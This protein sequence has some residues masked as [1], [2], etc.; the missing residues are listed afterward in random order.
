MTETVTGTDRSNGVSWSELLETDSHPV[1]EVL[2]RV[3]PMP[4][5]NT[6]VPAAAYTSRAW[7][8]LE[9]ER[10]WSRV[11]QMACLEEDIPEVGDHLV[12]DIAHLSFVVVR[13]G[14]DEI[15]AFNNACL[16]RGRLLKEG[17]GR[18]ATNLRCPFHGWSWNLDGSLKEIPCEWDFPELDKGL[19]DL[20]QA[21]VG[22]WQ[23]FVFINPD[24]A[25]EPL[26]AFLEGLDE[27][28]ATLP[29]T[30]RVKRAHVRKIMP[31]NW[32]ACQEAF[33]EAYHVVATHPTLMDDLGDANS[34]YDVFGNFS[35]AVSPHAVP[36]PHLANMAHHEHPEDARHF[37]RWRHP[38]NGHVY[39]RGVAAADG[40]ALVEVTD[41]NGD[42]SVFDHRGTW[43]EGPLLQADPHMCI[44]IGGPLLEG[45]DQ[46][47]LMVTDS[48]GGV[49]EA[50]TGAA[51]ARR[52]QLRRRWGDKLDVDG[53]SDAEMIDAIFYSVF[54]NLSP[55]GPFNELF[56]RFRPHGDNPDECIFEI[57]FFPPWPDDETRPPPSA[58]TELGIDDDWSL[59]PE[60][61]PA[62][63]IFQQ[64]SLNLPLVQKGLKAQQA[65]E[66]VFASYNESKIRHF[67]ELMGQWLDLE[68]QPVSIR[69]TAD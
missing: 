42:L 63:K 66:V 68:G 52:A 48:S 10:L 23:G 33:M 65:Q 7:H 67:W 4:P 60:M 40:T 19:L 16:H 14:A 45:M 24:P 37:A 8:D 43:I 29:F 6:R 39:T 5:G 27:H 47:P 3:A 30:K 12:Y 56:Y 61:G 46:V 36:S 22:T 57:M 13:T 53:F 17:P 9:V 55:W 59:A 54:P 2:T 1:S 58:V 41:R 38:M 26:E 20:P 69:S 50:R 25:A 49:V 44:W 18:G 64:D 32:K 21:R 34:A 62:F 28:F 11:W 31:V 15:R 35:R 51:E